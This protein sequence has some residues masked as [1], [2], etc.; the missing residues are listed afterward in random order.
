MLDNHIYYVG[1]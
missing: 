1:L